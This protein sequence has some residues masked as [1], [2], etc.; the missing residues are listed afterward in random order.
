MIK[1]VPFGN[2]KFPENTY[3]FSKSAI[4]VFA[5]GKNSNWREKIVEAVK[6][7]K[8]NAAITPIEIKGIKQIGQEK[9]R[10]IYLP[11]FKSFTSNVFYVTNIPFNLPHYSRL[12]D[13]YLNHN[14]HAGDLSIVMVAIEHDLPLITDD[15]HHW[16]L[17]QK[18]MKVYDER[19]KER[20]AQ[21]L[22]R[23]EKRKYFEMYTSKDFCRLKLI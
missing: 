7:G 22:V 12:Y 9:Y 8:I 19:H 20:I 17:Q 2:Y 1:L 14:I 18:F 15:N 11:I 4:N 13:L 10:K 16:S 23:K 3:A 5:E 21:C 6:N